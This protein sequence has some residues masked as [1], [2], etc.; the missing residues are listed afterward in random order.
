MYN[1]RSLKML[2]LSPP[3]PDHQS[4]QLATPT[5]SDPGGLACG[6]PTEEAAEVRCFWTT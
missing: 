2:L 4:V 5:V 6:L 3:F 1:R